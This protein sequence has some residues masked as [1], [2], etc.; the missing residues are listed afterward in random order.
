MFATHGLIMWMGEKMLCKCGCGNEVKLGR[1]FINGHNN[2]GKKPWNIG[3]EW[4]QETKDKIGLG[5]TGK[6]VSEETR[7]RISS[8]SIGKHTLSK[9]NKEKLRLSKIGK[10]RSMETRKK[11]SL[12]CTG[13]SHAN[14]EGTKEKMRQ[15]A[16]GRSAPHR[17]GRGKQGY[18]D[19]LGNIWFRSTW[20]AN[21]ART[22]NILGVP[23]KYESKRFDL[24]D[25]TYCPDFLCFPGAENEY[26]IEV[27]GYKDRKWIEKESKFRELYPNIKLSIIGSKEYDGLKKE[28]LCLIKEWE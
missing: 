20:E 3:H 25:T 19:D 15:K 23:Y 4:P 13:K 14:S 1:T 26:F 16:I 8:S 17:A 11:I 28:F 6:I 7:K 12:G 27:K 9:E 18:R 22:L 2:K 5:N 21:V 10:P 24:G